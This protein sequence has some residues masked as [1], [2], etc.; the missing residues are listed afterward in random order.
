MTI[1]THTTF[2]FLQP[3]SSFVDGLLD[4]IPEYFAIICVM[5]I[6]VIILAIPFLLKFFSRSYPMISYQLDLPLL[7]QVVKDFVSLS[8][9]KVEF[10]SF[11]FYIFILGPWNILRILPNL[12]NSIYFITFNFFITIINYIIKD[13]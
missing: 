13:T 4:D 8:D 10:H 5:G 11:F 12:I 1:Y 3:N 2:S 7:Q 6:R 9:I